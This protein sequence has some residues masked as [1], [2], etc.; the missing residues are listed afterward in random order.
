[1][2][3]LLYAED[4]SVEQNTVD[5]RA[6]SFYGP[7]TT[8]CPYG[9]LVRPVVGLSSG[10]RTYVQ[11]RKRKVDRALRNWLENQIDFDADDLPILALAISGG[12]L[13]SMLLGAGVVQ[14]LDYEDSD[15]AT[16][17]L[18]QAMTYHTRL[19]GGA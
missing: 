18:Y 19:S 17:G 4:L 7:Y 1:M 10:E 15:D 2:P 11:S 16:N 8:S 12:S 5:F 14:A 13:R 6:S 3:S 9:S